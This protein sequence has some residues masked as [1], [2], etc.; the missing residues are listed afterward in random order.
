MGENS[1]HW[2]MAWGIEQ[3]GNAPFYFY[4]W[5]IFSSIVWLPTPK[6]N[7]YVL[8]GLFCCNP[9][10]DPIDFYKKAISFVSNHK[11]PRKDITLKD[12]GPQFSI[13]PIWTGGVGG[14]GG[15]GGMPPLRYLC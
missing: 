9:E 8:Y 13:Y 15:G 5:G 12:F 6:R 14:G 3:L 4:I 11:I 2:K 1:A 7:S 10:Y